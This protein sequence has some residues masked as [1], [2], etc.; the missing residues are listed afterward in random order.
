ME[1]VVIAEE[2]FVV[3]TQEQ[4]RAAQ[5]ALRA[6]GESETEVWYAPQETLENAEEVGFEGAYKLRTKIFA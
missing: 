3:E 4:I 6:A 1:Y 2:T 5:E